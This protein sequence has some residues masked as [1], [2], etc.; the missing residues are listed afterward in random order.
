MW[1]FLCVR[2]CVSGG[3][4]VVVGRRGIDRYVGG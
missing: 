2:G 4:G 3:I 1:L